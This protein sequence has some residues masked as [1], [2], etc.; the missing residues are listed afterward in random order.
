[1][2]ARVEYEAVVPLPVAGWFVGIASRRGVI[3]AV[4]FVEH[5]QWALSASSRVAN[6][7]AQQLHCYFEQ[8]DWHFDVPIEYKGTP[9]QQRV[10]DALCRLHPG[11]TRSYGELAR[12]LNS[13]ARAVGGACR[14]NP[15]AII[16][17]CHRIVGAR[18]VGGFSGTTTG[19]QLEIKQW[20]LTHEASKKNQNKGSH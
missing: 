13:A 1:M 4:D 20:L 5:G 8:P 19:K 17:P 15:V 3:T 12:Q 7:A 18:D 14:A 11:E 2:N 6:D 16:V 10:W 9:F